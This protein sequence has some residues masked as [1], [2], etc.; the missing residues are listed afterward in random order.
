MRP[1][2]FSAIIT[3]L[4]LQL[5]VVVSSALA[6]DLVIETYSAYP[7]QGNSQSKV[8]FAH[9]S[10]WSWLPF[11]PS[12]G[13]IWRLGQDSVWS[14]EEHLDRTLRLL[15]GN[16]DV[17]TDGDMA[18]GALLESGR[19]V[20]QALAWD[21]LK[22]QYGMS[23]IPLSIIEEGTAGTITIDREGEQ[24]AFWICYPL[25]SGKNVKV[26]V[27]RLTP[28][29]RWP[30]G[31][32]VTLVE[33]LDANDVCAVARVDSTVGIMW[34]DIKNKVL[35]FRTRIP[36]G[37]ESQ[38]TEP[39]T[40]AQIEKIPYD[41]ISLCRPP[42]VR[43][44]KLLAATSALGKDKDHPVLVLLVLDAAGTWHSLQF[45]E[46]TGSEKPVHPVVFWIFGR[47]VV[48]YTLAGQAT[49]EASINQVLVQQ[50]SPDGSKTLGDP[51]PMVPQ[52]D[53]IDYV[54]APKRL[55]AGGSS[56]M[57]CSDYLGRVV[58]IGLKVAKQSEQ[59]N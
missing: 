16:A 9:E 46:Q 47:P 55:P 45:A 19:I 32:S 5:S 40:A 38:W 41:G 52:T 48:A 11:G 15:P 39:V 49:Q 51:L 13:R 44:V 3:I 24:G 2:K 1:V 54:S 20:I 57:F 25:T 36:G 8:W 26:V 14:A 53:G 56:L 28:N 6:A 34:S 27:R 50:F 18:A 10:W 33:K 43:A 37:D 23:S 31:N 35:R 21:S 59:T 29:F 58:E 4:L 30:V 42:D 22:N 7:T 12:G 17:W